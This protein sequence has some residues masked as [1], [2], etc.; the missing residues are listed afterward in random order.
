MTFDYTYKTDINVIQAYKKKSVIV[1]IS[2]SDPN[3]TITSG[4]S[5]TV[6]N[7]KKWWEN[8]YAWGIAGL[9]TGILISK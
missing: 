4:R 2:L 3:A 1:N 8:P 6:K 9:A 5:I 7:P